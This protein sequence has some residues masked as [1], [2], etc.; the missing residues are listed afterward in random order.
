[1]NWL[2]SSFRSGRRMQQIL[3]MA[4][5]RRRRNNRS[6]MFSIVGVGLGAAV[7]SMIRNRDMGLN[8]NNMMEPIKEAV[9]DM[10]MRNPIR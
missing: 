8:M 10:G 5:M 3:E 4:G 9:G 1:M 7:V 2:F 6:L